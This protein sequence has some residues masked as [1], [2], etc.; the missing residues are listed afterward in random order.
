M[1]KRTAA[2]LRQVQGASVPPG[3]AG[4][5]AL[6]G[7]RTGG[8]VT[9]CGV[10]ASL[11]PSAPC[12]TRLA[13]PGGVRGQRSV[14]RLSK[15]TLQQRGDAGGGGPVPVCGGES[16]PRPTPEPGGGGEVSLLDGS[17]SRPKFLVGLPPAPGHRGDERRSGERG[18]AGAQGRPAAVRTGSPEPGRPGPGAGGGGRR[19]PARPE[20]A[21]GPRS[22]AG[23]ARSGCGDRWGERLRLRLGSLKPRG[24]AE[25]PERSVHSLDPRPQA[26]LA[27]VKVRPGSLGT[28]SARPIGQR[29]GRAQ[30]G[31]AG[32]APG[33][34]VAQVFGVGEARAPGLWGTFAGSS[35]ALRF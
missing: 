30:P 20:W 15:Q 29:V 3:L 32:S 18:A 6:P 22:G 11:A 1:L 13:V 23:V 9:H 17:T 33:A 14:G 16:A 35:M 25:A 21:Q 2:L 4:I 5:P 27:G 24:D 26:G 19:I 7:W 34:R 12:L 31:S 8:S 28:R 10:S